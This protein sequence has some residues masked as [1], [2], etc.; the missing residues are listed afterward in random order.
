VK[1]VIPDLSLVL[2]CYNEAGLFAES[3]ARIRE[4]LDTS[5]LTY[6]IIFV[7]DHSTD[8]TPDLIRKTGMRAIFHHANQGRGKAVADGIKAAKGIVVGYMDIDCEVSPVYIPSMVSTILGGQADVIIGRRYYRSSLR[9]IVREILS[10]GY[11]WL[12]DALIG[13]AGLDTETGYKFFLRRKILPIVAKTKHSGWFWDTEI[14]VYS[15]RAGLRIVEVPVL[16]LRRF[17]KQSSVHIIRD[18]I[19]YMVQLVRFRK[20]LKSRK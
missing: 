8:Q 4:T 19:D 2:P 17:D 10:R 6:E 1:N 3:V 9:A 7:D 14:M 16:F 18:T 12:A 20:L 15:R 13:T 11:H 5:R